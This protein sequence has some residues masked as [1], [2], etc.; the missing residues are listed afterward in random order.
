MN[1]HPEIRRKRSKDGLNLL[2]LK[3]RQHSQIVEQICE[4]VC[5]PFHLDRDGIQVAFVIYGRSLAC[6]WFL[7][8]KRMFREL[9][10]RSSMYL[11]RT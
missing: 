3:L 1:A 10:V 5:E 2:V 7:L 11:P 6:V 8:R 9:L 4:I